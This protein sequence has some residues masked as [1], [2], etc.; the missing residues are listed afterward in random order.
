MRRASTNVNFVFGG[1]FEYQ[2]PITGVRTPSRVL[3]EGIAWIMVGHS[4]G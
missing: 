4:P 2:V 3:V 1:V